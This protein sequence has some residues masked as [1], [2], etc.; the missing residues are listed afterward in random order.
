MYVTYTPLQ[1][2]EA[3]QGFVWQA[4]KRKKKI[5][6]STRLEQQKTKTS[7]HTQLALGLRNIKVNQS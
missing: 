2:F 7:M 5:F 6:F 4:R 1:V 3:H